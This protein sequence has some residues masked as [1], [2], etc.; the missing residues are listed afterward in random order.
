MKNN[1]KNIC[2]D[3]ILI[4]SS[5]EDDVLVLPT[6]NFK[7]PVVT[8]TTLRPTQTE[9]KNISLKCTRDLSINPLHRETSQRSK[10]EM[11]FSIMAL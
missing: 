9:N 2:E 1:Q 6:Q 3:I 10:F 5:D 7:A 4:D 8:N 11:F